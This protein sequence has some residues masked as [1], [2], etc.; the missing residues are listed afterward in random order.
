MSGNIPGSVVGLGEEY[1]GGGEEMGQVEVDRK[2]DG[3]W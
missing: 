2:A 1:D 3:S